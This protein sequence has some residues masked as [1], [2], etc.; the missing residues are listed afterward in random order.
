MV[1]FCQNW[2]ELLKHIYILTCAPPVIT[3]AEGRQ[4][5]NGKRIFKLSSSSDTS[6]RLT[7]AKA[8]YKSTHTSKGAE[9]YNLTLCPERGGDL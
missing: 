5:I 7:F 8:C 9:P 4:D 3:V 1:G 6:H 2:T